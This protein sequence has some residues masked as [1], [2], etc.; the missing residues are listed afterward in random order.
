VV[1]TSPPI[2]F[3]MELDKTAYAY[4]E[5]MTI[6]FCLK[7][8]S[9]ETVTVGKTS[10]D[11]ATGILST[12]TKGVNDTIGNSFHMGFSMVDDN[13]TVIYERFKGPF[14]ATYEFTVEPDGYVRQIFFWKHYDWLASPLPRGTYQ[15]RGIFY[16]S[17]VPGFPTSAL[18]TP[19][20]AFIVE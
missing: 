12:E 10:M 11:F 7:N 2:E 1:I 20:I 3:S 15:I 17:C 4:G 19:S 9:N 6:T 5:N 18:V 14:Q 16:G 8:I 13:G